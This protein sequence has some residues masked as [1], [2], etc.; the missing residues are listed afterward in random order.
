MQ[1]IGIPVCPY[2][3]K[4]VNLIR[5]WTL[6]KHGEY[7]CPKCKGISNIYLSPLTYVFALIAIAAGVLIYFFENF[8]TDTLGLQTLLHVFIPFAAFFLISL[9]M[10][11]LE[12]PVIRRVRKTTD[13]RYFDEEGNEL[14]MR[15][16]KLKPTGRKS[17]ITDNS[18]NNYLVNEEDMFGAEEDYY[19]NSYADD[20]E[21]NT[22]TY[23]SP[24]KRYVEEPVKIYGEEN[25][26]PMRTA[27]PDAVAKVSEPEVPAV[28]PH[29]YGD[30]DKAEQE[31]LFAEAA[32]QARAEAEP[33]GEKTVNLYGEKTVNLYEDAEKTELITEKK[34]AKV[35]VVKPQPVKPQNTAQDNNFSSLFDEY[36][37]KDGNENR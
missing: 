18:D 29:E 33:E 12:R 30:V 1:L 3:R 4:S 14:E 34:P 13:G 36:F 23:E 22:V 28:M 10:V 35:Q 15:H 9:F 20:Y 27:A 16:G 25:I 17:N 32:R 21:D 24:T 7:R 26:Q 31:A 37:G 8:I 19:E 2:C 6:K 5:V 11:Y